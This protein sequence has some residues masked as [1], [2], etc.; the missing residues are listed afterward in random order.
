MPVRILRARASFRNR[1]SNDDAQPNDRL[2]FVDQGFFAGHRATG[3]TE[4]MQV[5]W[6]YEHAI[7]FDGLK[8]FH[9]NFGYGLS[10]RLIERSPVPFGRH[11]WV[12][13]RGPAEIHF[14]DRARPRA[15][16][17]DW[18]DERSQVPVDPEA[19]PG[20]HISVLPLTD[21][22]TAVTW[23]VSHY[24]IDGVGGL[25]AVADAILGAN[26][27][28]GYAPPRSRT[29][30][31][32]LAQDLGQT[33]RDAPEVARSLVALA[34]L[35]RRQ[36]RNAAPSSPAPRAVAR[37]VDEG[38]DPVIVPGI[39]IVV[40]L[41]QWDARA[42]S[43]GG[44]ST[45]LAA[46]LAAKL[47]EHVGRRRAS[48]G[49]VTLQIVM[50]DRTDGD[51]RALAVSFARVS[52]DP[53][54][55]TTDLRDAR[56]AI[57]EALK[58]LQS[59]P[60]ESSK[61][62]ALSPFTP[63]RTW[64]RGVEV[65]LNDHDMPVIYSNLGDAGSVVSRADGTQCEHAW[66][67]GTRQHATRQQLERTGGHMQVVSCRTPAIGK[68]YLTIVAYHPGAENTKP[69]MRELAARTLSEFGLTGEID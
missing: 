40:D 68:I 4:V 54:G 43:L 67:R 21:G 7:D 2:A 32:A 31:R 53:T 65:Q 18:A 10:G 48:D 26:R 61:L 8:R 60:D 46:A 15:D 37:R 25:V 6:V 1:A 44:T 55:L 14:A 17:S 3:Q 52:L 13:D 11:R 57:K 58:A 38:A 29:R 49:A 69:A 64:K 30:L 19:G 36:R 47:G 62:A 39:A 59:T 5:V 28:L 50:T 34:K 41:D 42:E 33:A 22:S 63:K 9:H 45:T 66:A 27:D 20:W 35:S 16:L 12:V 51:T 23:V 56:A 24:I